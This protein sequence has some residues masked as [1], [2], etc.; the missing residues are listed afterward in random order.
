[1]KKELTNLEHKN[2]DYEPNNPA[3]R[4]DVSRAGKQTK[5]GQHDAGGDEAGHRDPAGDRSHETKRAELDLPY[6]QPGRD[7]LECMERTTSLSEA[8]VLHASVMDDAA[9]MLRY[10]KLSLAGRHVE[11]EP[12]AANIFVHGPAEVID[13]LIE[14]GAL[15]ESERSDAAK[16]ERTDVPTSRHKTIRMQGNGFDAEID[17]EIA[18]LIRELW[19]ARFLTMMSCQG[20]PEGWVWIQFPL[21]MFAEAF[22]GL[23]EKEA[24]IQSLWQH[25]EFE[26]YPVTQPT[27]LFVDYPQE[28]IPK[29]PSLRFAVSV[30]F[31]KTDL[32]T[33]LETVVRHNEKNKNARESE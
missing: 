24:T 12:E 21:V 18:P 25:W 20:S 7:L 22:M 17:E 33:V 4:N 9:R 27:A 30:R 3:G 19:K 11:I 1:L 31:P 5:H 6:F 10:F 8:L 16:D 2:M 14:K 29:G 15:K 26:I 32:P 28:L 23:I 13:A